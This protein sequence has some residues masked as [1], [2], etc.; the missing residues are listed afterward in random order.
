MARKPSGR[1]VLHRG[2]LDQVTLHVA[3]GLLEVGRTIVEL[4]SGRAPDSPLDPYPIGEGLP[5]QGGVLVFAAGGKTS[6]WSTRGPQP[7]LPRAARPSVRQHSVVAIIGFGF[8][9]R[10]AERGS[11]NHAG[12]PFLT[13]TR[14]EVAPHIPAI[15]GRVTRPRLAGKR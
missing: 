12:Q 13:P 5:K 14:D 9:G 6:G 4:A 10:L 8:P 2:K 1:V 7:R 15:V 3:D 11:V